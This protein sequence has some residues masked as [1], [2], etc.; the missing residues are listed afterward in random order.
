MVWEH[1]TS[2][3]TALSIQQLSLLSLLNILLLPLN[4]ITT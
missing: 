3:E 4:K 2:P 1:P